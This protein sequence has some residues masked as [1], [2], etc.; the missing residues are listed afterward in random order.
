MAS[1]EIF[2]FRDDTYSVWHR[3]KSLMRYLSFKAENTRKSEAARVAMIDVDTIVWMEC[4]ENGYAPLLLIET[5]RYVGGEYGKSC[6]AIQN[7]GRLS[8]L[9]TFV[10][11]YKVSESINPASDP[12]KPTHDID[13]FVVR[14]VAPTV[15]DWEEMR[16]QEYAEF[17]LRER[18][19]SAISV[20]ARLGTKTRSATG[21][22]FIIHVD[23]REQKP[24]DF[25][26]M[27]NVASIPFTVERTTLPTGDYVT[28]PLDVPP[29]SIVI[30]RKSLQDLY[31]TLSQH[32]LRFE[33]EFQRMADS[34]FGYR[35]LVIES[36]WDL[37]ANPNLALVH[38]TNMNPK[39]VTQTLL[40]WS[41]KYG[42]HVFP[43]P[44]RMYA[45]KLTFRMLEWWAKDHCVQ[46]VS[47]TRTPE[48]RK[49]AC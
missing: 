43:M 32:R 21:S 18:D 4:D 7:L 6:R 1:N 27:A 17:L 31:G 23:S 9:P 5:K 13:S 15:G 3:W 38:K 37:I 14:R 26:C 11:L 33:A 28:G 42:V 40:H 24:Y 12:N 2:G 49:L 22:P 10:V 25:G 8:N 20:A 48:E 39:S 35:A 36:P 46:N 29:S 34:G 45:E 44:N 19:A 41:Q 16:P 47:T 30:E